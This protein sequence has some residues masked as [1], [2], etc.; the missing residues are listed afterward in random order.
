MLAAFVL[1]LLVS[2]LQAQETSLPA[3]YESTL[4]RASSKR[5]Q[6]FEDILWPDAMT[7]RAKAPAATEWFG[8]SGFSPAFACMKCTGQHP[9]CD[10]KCFRRYHA[11]TADWSPRRGGFRQ[12]YQGREKDQPSE[13]R[14]SALSACRSDHWSD[15][16]LG[17]CRIGE[18]LSGEHLLDERTCPPPEPKN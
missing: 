15:S 14:E 7:C 16:S 2:P 13:A 8:G 18:C 1:A 11:C 9:A 17:T 6:I 3:A 10:V 5:L 4:K 12:S